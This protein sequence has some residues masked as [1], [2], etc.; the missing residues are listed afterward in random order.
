M[1]RARIWTRIWRVGRITGLGI[2]AATT[3]LTLAALY[4]APSNEALAKR[5]ELEIATALGVQVTVGTLRWRLLPSVA[6]VVENA[7]AAQTPPLTIAKLTLYPNLVGLWQRRIQ[8]DLAE[9]DG[10]VVPQQALAGLNGTRRV[11]QTAQSDAI[12]PTQTDFKP[13]D[14]PLKRIVFKSVTWINRLGTPV[15]YDGDIDFAA[16]WRP[17]QAHFSLPG[18]KTPADLSLVRQGVDDRW[19][20][21]IHLAKGAANGEVQLQTQADGRMLLGG[22]LKLEA[23]EVASALTAFNRRP[24]IAGGA[25]GTSDLKAS[26]VNL[27]ELAQ[28]LHTQ[29]LLAITGATL[30]RFDLNKAVRSLGKDHDGQTSLEAVAG[31]IDTQNGPQGVVITFTHIKARSGVLSASGNATLANRQV[32]AELA[33]DLVGGV[34]GV[35]LK[36]S[37]PTDRVVVTVPGSAIAGAV[38]GTAVLPGVGTAI[39]ARLGAALGNLLG[40]SKPPASATRLPSAKP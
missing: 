32:E 20:I 22:K 17:R 10:A 4:I 21:S 15:I 6:V 8:I 2:L 18:A 1:N 11:G 38:V 30:L 35:P 3:L 24:L 29:T 14:V 7:T 33:V 9:L 31:Q 19:R 13:A 5:A 23:I 34:V 12:Q 36:I 26:G 25:S 40:T 39:G 37:G 27:A 28:S 16:Q